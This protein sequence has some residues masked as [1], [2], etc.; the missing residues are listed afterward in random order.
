MSSPKRTAL[1]I[2]CSVEEAQAIRAAAQK[3]CRTISGY[4]MHCLRNRLKIEYDM[5]RYL[6]LAVKNQQELRKAST[7]A[8][9]SQSRGR[10]EKAG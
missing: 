7:V 8:G 9:G 5:E 3:Q 10:D 1:L 6:E 2:R 4:V